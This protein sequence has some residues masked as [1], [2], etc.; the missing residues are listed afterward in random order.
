MDGYHISDV[1]EI[2]FDQGSNQAIIASPS[3]TALELKG[4]NVSI[5]G[6]GSSPVDGN[7]T[8]AGDLTVD[9]AIIHGGGG[10]GTHTAKGGTFSDTIA[11]PLGSTTE[12]FSIDRATNGSMVFD[13]YFTNDTNG[14]DSSLSLIHI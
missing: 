8:V 13:V 9:G 3:A 2:R 11:C 1:E 6:G 12:A 4:A 7:L 14:T 5:T 10:S